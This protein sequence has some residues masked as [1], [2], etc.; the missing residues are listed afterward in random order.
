MADDFM[1]LLGRGH[2]ELSVVANGK[3]LFEAVEREQA[4]PGNR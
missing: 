4:P 3:A 1:A 2:L